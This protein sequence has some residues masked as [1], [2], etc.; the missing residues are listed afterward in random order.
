[1]VIGGEGGFAGF[2]L[3]AGEGLAWEE[4]REKVD[5]D[6]LCLAEEIEENLDAFGGGGDRDDRAAHALERA[7]GDFN[8]L[9]DL[10]DRAD[11]DRFGVVL[12]ALADILAKVFHE[13]FGHA[14]D[15]GA[16]TDKAAH[17]L[18]KGHGAFH[19]RELEFCQKIAW[20]EG[21][22]PPD[23]ATPG[24]FAVAQAGAE[25]LDAFEFLEVFGG[26]VFAFG[27]SANAKPGGHVLG[28]G[29][30]WPRMR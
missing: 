24:G 19:F 12:R 30:H 7:V 18:A 4:N 14:R 23:L 15:L 6:G 11:R 28:G 9:A 13:G 21:F 8:F 20:E 5:I 29:S 17:S 25:H 16:E 1:M 22:D 3:G 26:D 27:L 2:S 10:E